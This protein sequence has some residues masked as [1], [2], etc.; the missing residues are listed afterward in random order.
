MTYNW[1][2]AAF[3]AGIAILF[4]AAPLLEHCRTVGTAFAQQ[5]EP[6]NGSHCQNARI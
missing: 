6:A 5:P 2:G 3:G 1:R 4:S